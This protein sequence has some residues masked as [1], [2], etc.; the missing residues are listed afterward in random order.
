MSNRY[1]LPTKRGD[2]N[3]Q[4][5]GAISKSDTPKQLSSVSGN[6]MPLCVLNVGPAMS[7]KIVTGTNLTS[8][9]KGDQIVNVMS[10]AETKRLK[11]ITGL[12]KINNDPYKE[13]RTKVLALSIVFG[14]SS[15][16]QWL[17][18]QSTASRW[19]I[20]LAKQVS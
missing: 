5:T 18:A 7:I 20:E 13:A 11:G 4:S 16:T 12:D 2:A 15:K 9:H 19:R 8:L 1:H 10:A 14:L 6:P 17:S 3:H